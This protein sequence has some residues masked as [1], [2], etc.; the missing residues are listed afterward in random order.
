LITVIRNKASSRGTNS[1]FVGSS[2]TLSTMFA[3]SSLSCNE[4]ANQFRHKLR[5]RTTWQITESERVQCRAAPKIHVSDREVRAERDTLPLGIPSVDLP[6]QHHPLR[7]HLFLLSG[8]QPREFMT[9]VHCRNICC[10]SIWSS[11]Y[12]SLCVACNYYVTSHYGSI[13][14]ALVVPG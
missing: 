9:C 3:V 2:D 8:F 1:V 13:K 7:S 10:S 5:P 6:L 11:C 12:S 4:T 14:C